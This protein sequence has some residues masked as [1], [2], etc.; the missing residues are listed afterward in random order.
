MRGRVDSARATGDN[1]D[2]ARRQ[3]M[4]EVA[5]EFGR[6]RNRFARTDDGDDAMI[7]RQIVRYDELRRVRVRGA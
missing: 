1:D 5:R 3:S 6:V 7:D 4:R 2:A